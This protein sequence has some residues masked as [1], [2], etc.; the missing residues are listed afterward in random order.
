[1]GQFP[2]EILGV[3]LLFAGI[4]LA[5]AA[6]DMLVCEA[7]SLTGSSGALGFFVG[8]VLGVMSGAPSIFFKNVKNIPLLFSFLKCWM[9]VNKLYGLT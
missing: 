3:L 5:M 1:M 8:I 4:E 9:N 6:K 2:I 7:V